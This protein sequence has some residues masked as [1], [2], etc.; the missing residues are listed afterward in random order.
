MAGHSD[1]EVWGLSIHPSLPN[2]VV[3][4][5][6][7]NKICVWDMEKRC[8]IGKG[9]VNKK[10]GKKK[11]IG[12]ASTLSRFPP[13]Q[14]SRACAIHPNNGHIAVSDNEGQVT[15]RADYNDIDNIIKA[16]KDTKQWNEVMEYSPDGNWLAVGSHD[17]RIRVYDVNGDYKMVGRCS[18]H[19][20]YIHCLD[21]SVDSNSL[22]TVCG[23]YEL[24]YWTK[25]G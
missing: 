19:S 15:I 24:L 6:D 17:N 12:G 4:S 21:W 2:I 5:C 9:T 11:K 25:D 22:R 18:G 10:R 20:S 14:C 16:F 23:G 13:N 7:D 3:T 8:R 1:G